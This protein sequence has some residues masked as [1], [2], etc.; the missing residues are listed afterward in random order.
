MSNSWS[1]L[2]MLFREEKAFIC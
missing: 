2:M 1:G